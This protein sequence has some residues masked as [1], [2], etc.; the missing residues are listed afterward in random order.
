HSLS[1]DCD[2]V[3]SNCT[4]K[5]GVLRC[6]S[7]LHMPF[8]TESLVNYLK[9]V[10]GEIPQPLSLPNERTSAVPLFLR[11]HYRFFLIRLF[12]RK[13]LF[14]IEKPREPQSTPADYAKHSAVLKKTAG[15]H[16]VLV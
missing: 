2:S 8:A 1:G 11:A 10:T 16:V 12:G 6:I 7:R 4:I 9:E 13:H 5:L 3:T 15:E 14:A